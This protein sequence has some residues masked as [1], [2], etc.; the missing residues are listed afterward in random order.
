MLD[1]AVRLARQ[2]MGKKRPTNLEEERSA[3]SAALSGLGGLTQ[4]HE[5]DSE[6]EDFSSLMWELWSCATLGTHSAT[7]LP[8]LPEDEDAWQESCAEL[9]EALRAS[10]TWL[11]AK[12]RLRA[13][14][15]FVCWQFCASLHPVRD[16][17]RSPTFIGI[18][19]LLGELL[20]RH[21]LALPSCSSPSRAGAL[22]MSL[23]IRFQ[24]I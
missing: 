20:C 6:V 15:I 16:L 8:C 3:F 7:H 21:N 9:L 18:C 14:G 22:K 4:P 11:L 10:Q 19:P 24:G 23:A 13:I 2:E 17:D 12:W 1:K 5:I